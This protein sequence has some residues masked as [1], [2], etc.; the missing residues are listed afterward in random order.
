MVPHLAHPELTDIG[1]AGG[2]GVREWE[3]FRERAA[4]WALHRARDH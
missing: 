1:A 2:G 3:L 4:L